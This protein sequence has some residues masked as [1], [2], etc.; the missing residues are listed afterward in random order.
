M[1]GNNADWD[2]ETVSQFST[3][4][5]MIKRDHLKYQYYGP[6]MPEVLFD[7]KRNPEETINFMDDPKYAQIIAA[8]RQRLAELGHGPDADPNYVNAGYGSDKHARK[9]R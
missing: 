7:L 9:P 3:T 5:V 1:E 2:N 8:F 6:E 4:N